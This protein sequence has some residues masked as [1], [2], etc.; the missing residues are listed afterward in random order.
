VRDALLRRGGLTPLDLRAG[1]WSLCVSQPAADEYEGHASCRDG[2]VAVAARARIGLR[3]SRRTR[4]SL[5]LRVD[6]GAALA[7]RRLEVTSTTLRKRCR[8][9]RGRR[10]TSACRR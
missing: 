4:A 7:G 1:R 3:L 9:V 10:A 2:F 6:I 8:T 5:R